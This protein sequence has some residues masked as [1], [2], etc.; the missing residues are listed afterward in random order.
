MKGAVLYLVRTAVLESDGKSIH[1][2]VF[3]GQRLIGV[4]P[5]ARLNLG[6]G[7]SESARAL[8]EPAE[9]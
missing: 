4:S 3:P 1:P 8:S 7:R 5:L 2:L 6:Q 9:L